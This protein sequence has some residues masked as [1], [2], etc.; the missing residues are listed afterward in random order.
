MIYMALRF[1]D[2]SIGKYSIL[3]IHGDMSDKADG[4]VRIKEYVSELIAKGSQ[5]IVFDISELQSPSSDLVGIINEAHR[6]LERDGGTVGVVYYPSSGN[7]IFCLCGVYD[8][9]RHYPSLEV[10]K[11]E[12]SDS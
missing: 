9:A 5:H 1:I 3:S 7:D 12:A 4:R 6:R 10:L 8:Y 11:R 2:E